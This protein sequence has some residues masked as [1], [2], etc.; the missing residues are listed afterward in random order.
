MAKV[1]YEIILKT[2]PNFLWVKNELN[3][4]LLKK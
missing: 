3:P 2:E 4:E 1:Y